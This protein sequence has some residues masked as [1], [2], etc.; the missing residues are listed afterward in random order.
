MKNSVVLF[1]LFLLLVVPS[2]AQVS[3]GGGMGSN[4]FLD[5]GS[6]DKVYFA[7]AYQ[8]SLTEACFQEG[9]P[10]RQNVSY[11]GAYGI[12]RILPLDDGTFYALSN[13]KAYKRYSFSS[14][15]FSWR[16][17]SEGF[18]FN[19]D[20]AVDT[21]Y[22]YRYRESGVSLRFPYQQEGSKFSLSFWNRQTIAD[23][24]END[25]SLGC[26]DVAV[27]EGRTYCRTL[28]QSIIQPKQTP[29][30]PKWDETTEL[31][32]G[33]VIN[34]VAGPNGRVYVLLNNVTG[35][36]LPGVNREPP[37]VEYGRI[38]AISYDRNN[39]LIVEPVIERLNVWGSPYL[40]QL[41][42]S[43]RGVYFVAQTMGFT[44]KMIQSIWF[45]SFLTG[46]FSEVVGGT[47]GFF[48]ALAVMPAQNNIAP[49]PVPTPQVS[50]GPFRP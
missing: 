36:N 20:P 15:L 11:Y 3:G 43:N 23:P 4:N 29:V 9:S 49:Q 1:V 13:D 31:F 17:Y 44:G 27:V 21:P 50:G 35:T 34:M 32:S 30:G 5:C 8:G 45:K 40:D 16:I 10:V 47:D 37:V 42:V 46:A 2:F 12:R 26:A 38:V 25:Q 24:L 6:Q 18:G 39:R 7:D 41:A 33:R 19:P 22:G 28:Y 48:S 14:E